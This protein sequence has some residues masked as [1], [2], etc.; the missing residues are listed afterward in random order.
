MFAGLDAAVPGRATLVRRFD[1]VPGIAGL[2]QL[3]EEFLG[4][5]IEPALASLIGR[6]L[7]ERV[8]PALLLH[9]EL[10]SAKIAGEHPRLG[11]VT[12]ALDT[13]LREE[14]IREFED[15]YRRELCSEKMTHI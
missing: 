6:D 2:V 1:A 12:R 14:I 4:V 5:P 8:V 7:D 13:N 3:D 15:V 9:A 11:S 10:Q